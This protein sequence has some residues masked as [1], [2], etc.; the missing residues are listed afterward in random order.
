MIN[1]TLVEGET[2]ALAAS[3]A[4]EMDKALK[5]FEH[6]LTAIR[7]GRASLDMLHGITAECYGQRMPL[8]DMATLATPEARL[9]TI[10]PWDKGVLGSIEKGILASDLG[11][12][13]IN[14]GNI[15][16]LQLPQMSTERR[17]ELVK[18]LNKKEEEA[19]VNV[20]NARR[21]HISH[22]KDVQKKGD[23]SE[24]FGKRLSEI[25]EKT[26][27]KY[28]AKVE[29]LTAKKEASIHIV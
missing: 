7:T 12:T 15:I 21:E 13:P 26:N 5:H 16:R 3:V 10:Q 25:V 20:R 2:N 6:E 14:D 24:D 1:V 22:I 27:D 23:V 9:I 17:G 28:M 8:R 19:K 4:A 29:E 11:L 18:I